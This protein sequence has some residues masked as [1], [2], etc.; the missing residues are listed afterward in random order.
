MIGGNHMKRVFIFAL[1]A[2]AAFL[3]ISCGTAA[4]GF[5]E[6]E[7]E[8]INA[9]PDDILKVLTVGNEE[10]LS[11]LRRVSEDLSH[12]ELEGELYGL[13]ARRMV[14]TVS[15]STVDGVG[16]AAPQ[17]GINRNIVAVQR[18]D[19][20]GAPF[21]VYPNI[22]IVE[23]SDSLVFGPEGCLSVPGRRHDV[24][25]ST[26]VTIRYYS[27]E[28]G[29]MVEEKIEG[30]T[31]VIFQHEVDHLGGVLYIDRLPEFLTYAEETMFRKT[32]KYDQTMEFFHRLEEY[33]PMVNVTS[34][35]ES[36]LGRELPLVIVDKDGLRSP[37]KIRAKGRVIILVE[38]CIHSGEPD[39][40]DASMIFLRDLVAEK[41]NIWLLDDVSFLFIPI[42][43]VDGHENFT[44]LNR[45]NQNGPDELGTRNTSQQLNLNRD[46]LKADAPEMR[47][48]LQM[49]NYWLPELFIDVHVTNGADFQYVMTYAIDNMTGN[50]EPGITRW[51]RDVYEKQLCG[52]M[53]Q[54][55]YP[56]FPYGSFKKYNA[57]ESG[58]V[59]D[60][61]DPR[62]SQG[63]AAAHNRLG[64][65]IENHIYKP[66]GQRVD[67][68]VKALWASARILAENKESLV[69]TL[70]AADAF[71]SSPASRKE[72][73]G[74]R[75]RSTEDSPVMVDYL[76]WGRDTVLSDLSG[77]EWVTH[78]YSDPI[79]MRIPFYPS[80]APADSVYLP[81]A[82]ILMPQWKEVVDL[83]S[84]HGVKYSVLHESGEV[85]VETYR[86]TG[87]KF[88]SRQSEGRIPVTPQ[89]TT[90]IE[91]LQYPAG[92]IYIDMD[93][94]ASR[95][96]MWLLEPA[97]PGSL[98]YWG[99][100]NVCVQAGNEF[101]IRPQYMEVKGREMLAADPALKAEFEKKLREDRSFASSPQAILGYF[102]DI[103]RK[104]AHQNNELHPAWRVL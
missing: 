98:T 84:L 71:V 35:G 21:E 32:P 101:W 3:M 55:G 1:A 16:L 68:T 69:E 76:S 65:L 99:F 73:F 83:L 72:P 91:K 47:A 42:F 80:F 89:Y 6:A 102:Y 4:G 56:I 33:S 81:K 87:G 26:G 10:E 22:S 23:Y 100:F 75:Y 27:L 82:Y 48:W 39:G 44:A 31:A 46:F 53:E 58:F 63:Y 38:S 66:Y 51:S 54:A 103:V 79:T 61:F 95:V 11:V 41:K 57:P 15:D 74:F 85:E 9:S 37:E 45:I 93:Q 18:F 12:E 62:Y 77:G 5:T 2:F 40:K 67:A 25:R 14:E 97:A 19:K 90:H 34:F 88:S 96:A 20:P 86:Y 7:K 60:T 28:A 43:N 50:M 8:I 78:D 29:A 24:E 94:P 92:S 17:I 52:M 104:R 59:P 49:Y 70:A 30:F 64:L 13:L 36:P